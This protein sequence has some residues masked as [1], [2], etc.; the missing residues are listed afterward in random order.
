MICIHRTEK[1]YFVHKKFTNFF[2][3][4]VISCS[5][6]TIDYN[7]NYID[8]TEDLSDSVHAH[9]KVPM[10]AIYGIRPCKVKRISIQ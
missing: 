1:V 9:S 10:W 4:V 7:N 8:G 6:F 3:P 2:Q 5:F